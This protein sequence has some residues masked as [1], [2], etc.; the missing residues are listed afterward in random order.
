MT[1]KNKPVAISAALKALI[2]SAATVG[3]NVANGYSEAVKL[4]RSIGTKNRT[5]LAEAGKRYTAG[6][7]ARYLGDNATYAKRWHNMD[8]AARVEAALLVLDKA[9][10][11]SSKSDRRSE[12]EHKACRAAAVSL[13][14]AKR[15]AGLVAEKKG[16]RKPRPAAKATKGKAPPVDLVKASPTLKTRLAANDYFATACAALLATVNKN[17]KH[18][19][20]RVATAVS[21]FHAALK[22]AGLIKTAE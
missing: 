4:F 17:A 3:A 15:R 10:P 21:D 13:A 14:T 6:Y 22:A 11:D 1:K 20:P 12:L 19:E 18:V 7:V 5:A 2:A 9:T 8:D 16:G